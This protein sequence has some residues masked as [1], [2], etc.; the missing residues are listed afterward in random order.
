MNPSW[1]ILKHKENAFSDQQLLFNLVMHD[2]R[3]V[4]FVLD[5]LCTVEV[6][7]KGD[8]GDR[9]EH[10]QAQTVVKGEMAQHS[11]QNQLQTA[12][13]GFQNG[14]KPTSTYFQWF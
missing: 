3:H 1:I 10:F 6:Q 2:C 7:R 5:R 11:R 8:N 12:S 9:D 13:E 4:F 14:I